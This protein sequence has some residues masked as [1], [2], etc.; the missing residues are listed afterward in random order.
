MKYY[1]SF[2][3]FHLLF[4][5]FIFFDLIVSST[6]GVLRNNGEEQ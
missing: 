4:F 5:Q 2:Q 3:G 1:S 6:K